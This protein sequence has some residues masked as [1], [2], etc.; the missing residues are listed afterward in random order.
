MKRV[1]LKRILLT[2]ITLFALALFVCAIAVT[3]KQTRDRLRADIPRTGGTMKQL[4]E[5]EISR[6]TP[7]FVRDLH[8]IEL[9]GLEG[10]GRLVHFCAE[11]TDIYT[12]PVVQRCFGDA[13]APVWLPA[14]LMR[15]LVGEDARYTGPV[16]KYPGI[17]VGEL[18]VT[19]NFDSVA[20]AA[21]TDIRNLL[22]ITAGVLLL[23]VL[24]YLPVRRVLGPAD[25]ILRGL[26]RMESGD[27]SVRLPSFELIELQRI[28]E[29]FNHLAGQLARTM[30][31][32]RRLA[33]RLLDVREE[34]RR[35]LARELHDE[36][37]QC[38]TSIQA[39]AA[40]VRELADGRLPELTPSAEAISRIAAHMME[41]LQLILRELRPV[42]LEAF[43]LAA[44]LEQLIDSRNRSSHGRCRHTLQIRGDLTALADNLN[45]SLYRIVQES[46]TNA[47]KHAGASAIA[48][49]LH[50]DGGEVRLVVDDDG[51]HA[52]EATFEGGLGVLG[53]RERVL[54]LGGRLTLAPRPEGGLRVE[55]VVPADAGRPMSDADCAEVPT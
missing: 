37:G 52:A 3:L 4:I 20:Q 8:G 22:L 47:Q 38:L 19:P 6:A 1:D 41:V 24:V 10:I 25:D 21:G 50:C 46:L 35:R 31:E 15:R 36:L 26:G 45:V 23:N 18:Q 13:V 27:L 32:Q 2:R 51:R 53:M 29:V 30:D 48:V 55:V 42:G 33:R 43:G 39:E 16:G 28:G 14:S 7:P 40:Y 17:K 54:A 11:V 5:S 12:R 9:S 34:E 44:T 49:A